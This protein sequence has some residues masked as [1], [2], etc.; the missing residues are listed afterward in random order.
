MSAILIAM[1]NQLFRT[2]NNGVSMP[3]L[4]FG[5]WQVPNDETAKA[6][7]AALEIG[8]RSIDTA[9]LYENEVAVGQAI[10][11]SGLPR[12]EL[13]ITTK[14]DNP[15]QG[16]EATLRAFEESRKKL[17]LDYVDLYLIHWPQ[18]AKNLYVESWLGFQKLLEDGVVRAIG[19]S[20]F[21][22]HHLARLQF[23]AP[24]V[25]PA[26][27]QI[28]L[29]P[30]FNQ[31]S[32]RSYHEAHGIATSAWSPLA[33]GAAKDG[34]PSPVLTDPVILTLAEKYEKS[35]AQIILRWH[36]QLGNLVIPKSVT[37]NRIKE[38]FEVFDFGLF[39]AEMR[40]ISDLERDGRNGPNPDL[41]SPGM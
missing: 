4:G 13:F 35:A 2:L 11:S 21:Q 27:N 5:T 36:L 38:N 14:L 22:E 30:Y 9:S 26:V 39:A 41:F 34:N 28:E 3:R 25:V 10:A 17:S 37:P 12:E 31:S 24:D 23:E 40:M 1:T 6:V 7:S 8:Y 33:S 15:D 19:V 32:L 18:P 16:R 29:N 20:N